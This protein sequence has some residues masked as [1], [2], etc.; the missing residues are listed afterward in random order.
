MYRTQNEYPTDMNGKRRQQKL[1]RD[2]EKK[3]SPKLF[4]EYGK[5]NNFDASLFMLNRRINRTMYA[6]NV[7]NLDK[8]L[9]LFR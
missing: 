8:E 2:E 3:T 6:S 1:Q 7:F 5:G 4:F 9:T